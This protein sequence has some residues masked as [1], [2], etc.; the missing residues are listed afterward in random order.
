MEV[1]RFQLTVLKNSYRYGTGEKAGALHVEMAVCVSS[2]SRD[3]EPE[4]SMK[5]LSID[6]LLTD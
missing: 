6:G 1:Q 3:L 4:E 5:S 2:S